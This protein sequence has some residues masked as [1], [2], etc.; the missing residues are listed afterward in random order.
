[1]VP[2]GSVLG[3]LLF[4]IYIDD[5]AGDLD[6]ITRLFADDTVLYFSASVRTQLVANVNCTLSKALLWSEKWQLPLNILKCEGQLFTRHSD[7][8]LYKSFI[9]LTIT[10]GDY[11][12]TS[13]YPAHPI[14]LTRLQYRAALLVTGALHLTNTK[15]VLGVL[16]WTPLEILFRQHK[17]ILFYKIVRGFAPSYLTALVPTKNNQRY[18]SRS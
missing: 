8:N 3:P 15:N 17:L 4:L 12:Y 10:Y 11:V 9:L 1:G 18:E 6:C 16:G 5:L 14:C 7:V 13:T 2:Q